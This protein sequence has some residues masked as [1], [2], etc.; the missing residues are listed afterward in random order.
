[1][2]IIMIVQ[3]SSIQYDKT[4]LH[5]IVLNLELMILGVQINVSR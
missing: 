5:V 4:F 2:Y 1:M 3:T